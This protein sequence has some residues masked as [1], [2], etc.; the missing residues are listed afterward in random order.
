MLVINKIKKNQ[1]FKW[2]E[3]LKKVFCVLKQCLSSYPVLSHYNPMFETEVDT[4][5]RTVGLNG[6]LLQRGKDKKWHLVYGVSNKTTYI[7]N[8]YHSSKLERTARVRALDR[9]R[10]YFIGI[11]FDIVTDW[12][13]LCYI[14][15]KK[16]TNSQTAC[17]YNLIPEF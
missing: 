7:V 1:D 14:N 5:A 13:V 11:K 2:K 6:I 9:L 15:L 16:T 3:E 10:Q 8:I 17:W 4:D 12:Q